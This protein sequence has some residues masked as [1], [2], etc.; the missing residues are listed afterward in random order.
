MKAIFVQMLS[1]YVSVIHVKPTVFLA[2][3]FNHNMNFFQ[4]TNVYPGR[5]D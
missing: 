1:S 4:N 3:I 5:I 2:K